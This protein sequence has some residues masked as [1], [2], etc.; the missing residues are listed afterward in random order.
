MSGRP[1]AAPP[2]LL[3]ARRLGFRFGGD[4]VLDEVNLTLRE[5]ERLAVLGPNGGGKTTLVRLLLGLLAP[6][7]G[8]I[9]WHRPREWRR[10]AYV[11]QFPA[12]E[13]GFPLR[14][15]EMVLQGCLRDRAPLRRYRAEDRERVDAL[16]AALDLGELRE[17]YLSELSGGQLKRAL[18]ARALAA[19][20][21]FLVL[22]EPTASLDE[23]S[24]RALWRL[25]GGLP[26]E[27]TAL[28]V[29]HDLAPDT[30]APSR[31]VLVDRGLEELAIDGLHQHPAVCGHTHG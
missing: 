7:R 18:V 1:G 23:P 5:G 25:L 12:F 8:E 4:L 28:L 31:A 21:N 30:F 22:D 26:E 29:T 6:D 17:A 24:R 27:T 20:P 2:L 3:E 14:V 11:P 10:L 15:D 19:R 9:A 16:L 13:R